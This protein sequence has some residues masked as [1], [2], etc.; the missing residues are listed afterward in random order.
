MK[1][2]YE[3]QPEDVGKRLETTC[4]YGG[5]SPIYGNILAKDV[6]KRVYDVNGVMQ[7]ES[8]RQLEERQ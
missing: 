7:I 3:I 4:R 2:L 5:N 6:G 1:F 8:D